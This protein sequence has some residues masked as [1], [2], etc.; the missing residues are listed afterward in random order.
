MGSIFPRPPMR[1]A[2]GE[3]PAP[4]A[5]LVAHGGEPL[6][7]LEGAAT[8]CLGSER[9]GLP[10]AV[11]DECTVAVTIPLRAGA[12]SLNVAAAAAIAAQ[13]LSSPAMPEAQP[14]A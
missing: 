13:R 10:T 4:R 2:V 3:T 5:A 12:E 9:E 8:I 6:D 11:L 7:A 14:D 1:A